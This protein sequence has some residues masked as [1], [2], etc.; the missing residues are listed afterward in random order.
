MI[1]GVV[2]LVIAVV[3]YLLFRWNTQRRFEAENIVPEGPVLAQFSGSGLDTQ[4]PD[5]I[6]LN[7][8][9]RGFIQSTDPE[10]DNFLLAAQVNWPETEPLRPIPFRVMD[11]SEY[12]CWGENFVA[13]DGTTTPYQETL[14]LID[15][16][17]K[18]QAPDQRLLTKDE[19]FALLQEGSPVLLALTKGY[20][21]SEI[22]TVF[23][24]VIIGCQ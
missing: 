17:H 18:L 15:D 5:T 23:Q 9:V 1:I 24:L 19:A 20:D 12:L 3:A 10:N 4:Y 14:F 7:R 11:Q 13:A 16:S 21:G 22:N 2:I 8:L 6:S